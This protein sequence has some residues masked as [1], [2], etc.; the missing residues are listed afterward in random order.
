MN[1]NYEISRFATFI[2]L[3]FFIA[4]VCLGLF[5]MCAPFLPSHFLTDTYNHLKSTR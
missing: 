3:L 4:I 1:D 5:A 2:Y